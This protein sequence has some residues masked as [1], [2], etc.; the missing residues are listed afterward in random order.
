[1]RLDTIAN[2]VFAV[3]LILLSA[4]IFAVIKGGCALG[5]PKWLGR[6]ILG[7]RNKKFQ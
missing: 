3:V 4:A 5:P 7:E 1:M 2:I 6:F